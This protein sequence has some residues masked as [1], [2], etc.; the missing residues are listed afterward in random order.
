MMYL[1][2]CWQWGPLLGLIESWFVI[3]LQLLS[4]L[5]PHSCGIWSCTYK[6]FANSWFSMNS[7]YLTS[8][9]AMHSCACWCLTRIFPHSEL[10]SYLKAT[11][12]PVSQQFPVNISYASLYTWQSSEELLNN[13]I[14]FFMPSIFLVKNILSLSDES[15]NKN[16]A[17]K[18]IL[19]ENFLVFI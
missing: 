13:L 14:C 6:S 16:I 5:L 10:W 3:V 7:F 17:R 11:H 12:T 2:F 15:S 18:I 1:I 9:S 4:P 19:L 8:I